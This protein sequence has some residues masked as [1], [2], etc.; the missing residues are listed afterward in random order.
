MIEEK[1]QNKIITLALVL[2]IL[3][4][5]IVIVY[6]NLPRVNDNSNEKNSDESNNDNV[7]FS[8][9][10]QQESESGLQEKMAN[11]TLDELENKTVLEGYGGYRTNFPVIK[12]Q[13]I[14]K[15]IPIILLVN[16]TIGP[17]SNYSIRV[18]SNEDGLIENVTYDYQQ[19]IGNIDIYNS[20]NAS[21]ETPID[22]GNVTMILC[23]RYQDEYLDEEKEGKLKIGFINTEKELITKSSLWWKYVISIE[24]IKE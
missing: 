3:L 13:G 7:I 9:I 22:K 4:A 24:V 12:G 15:G 14:Y 1:P 23:Y 17:L 16:N 2:I 21:D 10:W 6:T 20:T 18:T 8:L 19:I 5:I 11:F